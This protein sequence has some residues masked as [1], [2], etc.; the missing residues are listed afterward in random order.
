MVQIIAQ[1]EKARACVW[2]CY[3]LSKHCRLVDTLRCVFSCQE[4]PSRTCVLAGKGL[5]PDV[6][7]T[8]QAVPILVA[9]NTRNLLLFL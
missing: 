1:K 4:V 3:S 2:F 7:V 6:S 9:G 5:G 8:I